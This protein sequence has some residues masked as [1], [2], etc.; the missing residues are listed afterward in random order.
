MITVESTDAGVRVTIPPGEVTAQRLNAF[1]DWL[2]FENLARQ[3]Q[4]SEAEAGRL[5]EDIKAD[6]WARNKD[7]FIPAKP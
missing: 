1:L 4:L 2:R 7:R 6:W 5:A 3:S